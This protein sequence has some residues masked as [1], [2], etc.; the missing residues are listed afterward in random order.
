[1][2]AS[3]LPLDT[4]QTL[5]V[6]T[7]GPQVV[8]VT[9]RILNEHPDYWVLW[10]QLDHPTREISV[11]LA[12]PS[13]PMNTNF[14]RTAYLH[15]LVAEKTHIPTAEILAVDPSCQTMP[16]RTLIKSYIDGREWASVYPLLDEAQRANAFHQLGHAIAELHSIT[17]PQ[18]G[19]IG[20]GDENRS[21]TYF[22]ALIQWTEARIKSPRLREIAQSVL[23]DRRELF[24]AIQT[25][26]LVH[27]DLHHYNVLFHEDKGHWTLAT[28]LDFDKSWAGNPESDLARLDLWTN[29]MHPSFRTAYE[30]VHPTDPLYTQRRPVH[31]LLWC[32]EFAQPSP[33]HLATTRNVCQQLGIPPIDTF[34]D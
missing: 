34:S 30:A 29:M 16:Y 21:L 15:R 19:D 23:Q 25:P 13:S 18:F 26:C 14:D 10:A 22:D 17:L 8:L 28:I 7:F 9:H 31:Q 20:S 27:D 32:L 33:E 3:Y 6:Q 4:L 12:H 5:L 11:K 1:M 2:T 24:A